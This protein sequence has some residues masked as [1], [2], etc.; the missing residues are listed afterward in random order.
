MKKYYDI[1][2]IS[3]NSSEDD[4]K[5]AYR[6]MALKWHPDKNNNSEESQNKFKIISEAYEI[7]TRKQ[8]PPSNHMTGGTF[9]NPHDIFSALFGQQFGQQF[10]QSS[11]QG[12]HAFSSGPNI[13]ISRFS[14]GL[15]Q[16]G[17]STKEIRTM[18]EG[19]NKIEIIT[20]TS[21]MGK[22]TTRIIT[23]MKT[24]AKKCIITNGQ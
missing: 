19:D 6:K 22:K 24:G 2:G 23:N 21:H 20:E 8:P 12:F 14:N 3:S 18:F 11:F 13:N 16:R 4:V 15:P 7:L 10:N 9:N 1:L 5:K 17:M